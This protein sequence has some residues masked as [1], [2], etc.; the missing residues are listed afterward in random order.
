[1]RALL[2]GAQLGT[3]WRSS[4]SAHRQEGPVPGNALQGAAVAFGE[5]DART[6]DQVTH[7]A[8]HKYF[9][10]FDVGILSPCVSRPR[11]RTRATGSSL[12]VE[13]TSQGDSIDEARANLAEALTLYDGGGP[14]PCGQVAN[15]LRND[16]AGRP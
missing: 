6:G 13:V 8:G 11:S 5:L 15:R 3:E 14:T 10:I 1:L 12:E 16:P 4:A 2:D 9:V 7:G